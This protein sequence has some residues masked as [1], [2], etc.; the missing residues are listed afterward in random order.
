MVEE[1]VSTRPQT[2]GL[3]EAAVVVSS[4]ISFTIIQPN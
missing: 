2:M 3:G 4:I 1:F